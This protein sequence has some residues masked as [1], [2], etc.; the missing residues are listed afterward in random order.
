VKKRSG[1]AK[2]HR[3]GAFFALAFAG[4]VTAAAV[5]LL[6]LPARE[7]VRLS[8]VSPHPDLLDKPHRHRAASAPTPDDVKP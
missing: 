4:L 7:P 6:V 3:L 5:W 2:R 1:S 8:T